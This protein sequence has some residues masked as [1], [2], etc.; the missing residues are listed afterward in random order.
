[1]A[2]SKSFQKMKD[3]ILTLIAAA[4]L[5]GM[6][7]QWDRAKEATAQNVE[8]SLELAKVE[9]D[10]NKANEKT[11][12][13]KDFSSSTVVE[14]KVAIARPEPVAIARESEE[15]TTQEKLRSLDS[16]LREKVSLIRGE[17]N[18]LEE[19][20]SKTTYQL[21]ALKSNRAQAMLDRERKKVG[22]GIVQSQVEF[23]KLL[24][25]SDTA[26]SHTEQKIDSIQSS[27]NQ[28]LSDLSTV[29]FNYEEARSQ[30]LR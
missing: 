29:Q 28:K 18:L 21:R 9:R 2:P 4:A 7:Y 16:Q 20:L 3:I 19:E 6:G 14:D 25:Q 24:A 15:P 30:I 22:G 1:M 13:H 11:K 17:L 26:I 27:I 23:D 5:L 10:L 8:L 12:S